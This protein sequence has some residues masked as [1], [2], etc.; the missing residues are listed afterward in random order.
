MLPDMVRPGADSALLSI[1]VNQ[2]SA[3]ALA[4]VYAKDILL[5]RADPATLPVGM[6]TPPDLAINFLVAQRI[7]TRIPFSFFESATFVYDPDG[8][9][10]I[11]FGQRVDG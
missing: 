11:A 8:K 7:G 3:V 6:V 2:A 5:G 10:V 4:A 9:A 1:G